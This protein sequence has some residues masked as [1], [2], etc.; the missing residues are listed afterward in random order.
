MF[1]I[2]TILNL[3]LELV[4]YKSQGKTKNRVGNDTQVT[5]LISSNGSSTK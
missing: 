5:C 2:M 3:E 1:F 4:I